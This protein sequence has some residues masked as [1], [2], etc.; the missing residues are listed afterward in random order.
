[1]FHFYF[2][3][4]I[5]AQEP[6]LHEFVC[7]APNLSAFDETQFGYTTLSIPDKPPV[8]HLLVYNTATEQWLVLEDHRGKSL[9]S[10]KT[11]L[12]TVVPDLY[13]NINTAFILLRRPSVMFYWSEEVKSWLYKHY[14]R[15]H[16]NTFEYLREVKSTWVYNPESDTIEEH[17]PESC[18]S[19][20]PYSVINDDEPAPNTAVVYDPEN[21]K[22]KRVADY[23]GTNIYNKLTKE[24]TT[25]TE[26]GQL[27]GNEYTTIAPHDNS[28]WDSKANTWKTRM[29]YCYDENYKFCSCY[30]YMVDV[31]GHPT[32]SNNS[33]I[34][35][36]HPVLN[37]FNNIKSGSVT[38]EDLIFD[39]V[40]DKW[41]LDRKAYCKKLR[42][43]IN[44][45]SNRMILNHWVWN[46]KHTVKDE[47][48]IETDHV[49]QYT[50]K[51]TT[52]NQ[53]NI[54][55]TFLGIMF[56]IKPL[57]RKYKLTPIVDGVKQEPISFLFSDINTYTNFAVAMYDWIGLQVDIGCK[58]KGNMC[59]YEGP[60]L[61]EEMMPITKGLSQ[62]TD[63]ELVSFVDYREALLT[64]EDHC[65]D[66]SE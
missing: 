40:K 31:D 24:M 43:K 48:G 1:M 57:P 38:V 52:E 5:N 62:R 22:W 53:N 20:S 65:D 42:G 47:N 51:L 2:K 8:G 18:T 50:L 15:Y 55:V 3:R 36:Y 61:P 28:T 45:I 23:R 27:I 29:A 17:V 12:S 25:I 33:T 13:S 49:D 35:D 60:D 16:P 4:A 66:D 46:H 64:E 39:P 26:L 19:V 56:K 58:Y 41:K 54:N 6:D 11:W 14:Y 37:Y 10:R 44:F 21:K 63:E 34:V 32:L 9:V 30:I 7:S 59:V